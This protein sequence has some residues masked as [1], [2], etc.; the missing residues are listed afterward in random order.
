MQENVINPKVSVI[1]TSYNYAGYI[2]EAIDSVCS[3]TFTDWEL[4]VIDD[5]S[6]DNSI[7][8]INEKI[9]KYPD[10]IF[11][12]THPG[13]ENRN[14]SKSLELAFSKVT[15][16]YLAFLESDDK[17]LNDNLEKK[18]EV[19]EKF[20]RVSMVFSGIKLIGAKGKIPAKFSAYND[21][22]RYSGRLHKNKPMPLWKMLFIR[23][24][25]G[26]FSNLM[27]RT[28]SP[29]SIS[30]NEE[31]REWSDWWVA[32][33]SQALGMSFYVDRELVC[34]RI[35]E[36]SAHSVIM[37]EADGKKIKAKRQKFL[38]EAEKLFIE[39]CNE[40]GRNDIIEKFRAYSGS[41]NRF[42]YNAIHNAGFIFVYP[43]A[44]LRKLFGK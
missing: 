11:L 36:D 35:H 19:F 42:L 5:G 31:Y 25:V 2:G 8:I 38:E 9:E 3:Q 7:E 10:K 14:I 16:R 18:V 44:A 41:F 30:L 4:I 27:I 32:I 39:K 20:N 26:T 37:E 29:D 13:H 21:Y 23:N 22:V 6:V 43:G 17:W 28:N 33:Q 12:F 34:W 1:M 15:G 24:P 40:A